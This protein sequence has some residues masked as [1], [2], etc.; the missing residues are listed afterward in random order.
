MN[1]L[2][3]LDSYERADLCA[4]CGGGCCKSMPGS[5][6]PEDFGAPDRAVMVTRIRSALASGTWSVDWWEGECG[7]FESP[8]YLRPA[9]VKG[10]GR[11]YDASWGGACVFHGDDGCKIF[12]S[13][14]SGCRGL[15]PSAGGSGGCTVRHSSKEDCA[16]AWG[17]YQ[18]EIRRAVELIERGE[19]NLEVA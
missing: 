4:P 17:E 1:R 7:N 16:I 14:P 15:E 3:V 12:P 18:A 13:R 8:N 9:T 6:T 11:I 19:S 5:A 10:R 2:P